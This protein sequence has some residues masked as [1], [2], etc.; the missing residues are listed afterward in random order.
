ME[1]KDSPMLKIL[2]KFLLQNQNPLEV[3]QLKNKISKLNEAKHERKLAHQ[4]MNS[5]PQ[6]N[7]LQIYMRIGKNINLQMNDLA[8]TKCLYHA[9]SKCLDLMQYD[10]NN[11]QFNQFWKII[12]SGNYEFWK[13]DLRY[14][15]YQNDGSGALIHH[16]FNYSMYQ[17]D[18]LLFPYGEQPKSNIQI[19]FQNKLLIHMIKK[20]C[21][22]TAIYWTYL[23]LAFLRTNWCKSINILTDLKVNYY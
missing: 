4:I 23:M 20:F 16:L 22:L 7:F 10:Q 18:P 15:S 11:L 14:G 5:I 3:D 12:N 9:G 8:T 1:F 6:N 2:Q 13:E 21:A 19:L 17:M